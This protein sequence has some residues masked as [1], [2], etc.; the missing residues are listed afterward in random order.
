MKTYQTHERGSILVVGIIV[1]LVMTMMAIPFLVKLSAH[2]ASS[3]RGYRAL[4]AFNLAEAGADRVL[5]EM[6]QPFMM[7][8]DGVIT[9]DAGGNMVFGPSAE[10]VGDWTGHFQG[11]I[12]DN[13][14]VVPNIRTLTSTGT[15]P[16]I[17]GRT[18]D[19]TVRIVLEKY[20]KSIWDFGFFVD[21]SFYIRTNFLVDSYDSDKGAYGGSNVGT[22]GYFGTNGTVSGSWTINQGTSSIIQGAVAAGTGTDPDSLDQT[23]DIPDGTQGEF[24]K[25]ILSSQF[26][27][28]SLNM[29]D[30][31]AKDMFGGQGDTTFESWFT[32]EFKDSY[33]ATDDFT[34]LHAYQQ[35]DFVPAAGDLTSGTLKTDLTLASGA[36]RTLTAAD[37][38]IYTNVSLG[39]N[40]VLNVT[41]HVV[42]YVTGVEGVASTGRFYM[43][44][45]NIRI[46]DGGSLTVVL[47]NTT[48]FAENNWTIN[49]NADGSP[50]K[51]ANCVILGTDQF[52]PIPGEVNTT[53]GTKTHPAH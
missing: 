44:S 3:E 6:N 42:I 49:V 27:M 7:F 47:G 41:E 46:A 14:A 10:T 16:F 25:M 50:G 51:P 36:S 24:E 22:W 34:G 12:S 53:T 30:L 48:F 28:P 37:S 39:N 17:A 19:R 40:S 4:S 32:P 13:L 26:E 20:Y 8:E 1:T 38:G 45:G 23:L 29:F 11:I 33:L 21:E 2:S 35:T 43:D 31:P 5:W 52:Q 18:V 15:M 9:V